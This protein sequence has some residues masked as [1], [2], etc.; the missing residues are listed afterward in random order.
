MA[1]SDLTVIII[2][3]KSEDKIENCL[4][5]IDL[6]IKLIIIENS[7]NKKFQNY[8]ENRYKNF[9][10]TLTNDN[11]GYGKANNIGL[12]KVKYLLTR[13]SERYTSALTNINLSNK[14]YK[15]FGKES[16]KDY[17]NNFLSKN[18]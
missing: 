18:F 3:F 13:K 2:T 6:N 12:K 15:Y 11:L 9:E 14:V 8:I 1:N 16:V 4:N 5:S 10:C 17:I 7:N